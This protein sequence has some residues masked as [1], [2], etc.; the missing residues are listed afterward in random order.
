MKKNVAT[1]PNDGLLYSDTQST[2]IEDLF[3]IAYYP[4]KREQ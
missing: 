2:Y 3:T 4:C 1:Y